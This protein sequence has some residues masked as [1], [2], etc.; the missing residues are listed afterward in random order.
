MVDNQ[1]HMRKELISNQHRIL[2]DYIYKQEL[3][4]I[5]DNY[6][7]SLSEIIDTYEK[8]IKQL[9]E[10]KPSLENKL[11]PSLEIKEQ[12]LIT[13]C[14]KCLEPPI[15]SIPSNDKDENI[16]LKAKL[17]Y[18]VEE[19]NKYSNELKTLREDKESYTYQTL[20]EIEKYK[21][22][23]NSLENEYDNIKQRYIDRENIFNIQLKSKVLKVKESSKID[24][25]LLNEK[26]NNSIKDSTQIIN[27]LKYKI[28]KATQS[29]EKNNKIIK[30]FENDNTMLKSEIKKLNP[31][32]K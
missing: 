27:D 15:V 18:F 26:Y 21:Q 23:I 1:H 30:Q 31:R 11:L 25:D 20:K 29:E 24:Y 4:T 9:T 13:V 6:K 16:T 7:K 14:K 17:K 2:N 19:N 8:K 10:I 5:S 32:Y 28:L 22:R 3:K 12:Q